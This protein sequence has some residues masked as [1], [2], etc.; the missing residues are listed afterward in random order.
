MADTQISSV[1]EMQRG[2]I[3]QNQKALKQFV[4]AG[5]TASQAVVDS[6]ETARDVQH[7]NV[8]LTREAVTAYFD[9]L[10]QVAPDADFAP[11]REQV[12]GNFDQLVE[13]Q[14]DTWDGMLAAVEESQESVEE[15]GE[16]YGDLVESSFDSFLEAHEA[17]KE[18]LEDAE[19]IEF[20][21]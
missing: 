18:D 19:P 15:Y 7:Q 20:D 2:M 5:R 21:A 12:E 4:D 1:F 6:L 3:Q 13:T 8:E 16:T 10:E 9:A 17:V 14:E 11:V